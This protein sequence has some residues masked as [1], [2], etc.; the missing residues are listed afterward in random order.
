MAAKAVIKEYVG[1]S[2]TTEGMTL[3]PDV[4]ARR[5]A[6]QRSLQVSCLVCVFYR[7]VL[8]SSAA[9]FRASDA[10]NIDK[11]GVTDLSQS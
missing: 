10:R 1:P 11:E 2:N 9:F 4:L 6:T 8:F 7:R 3:Q 5:C